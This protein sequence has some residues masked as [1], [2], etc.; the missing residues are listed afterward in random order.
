MKYAKLYTNYCITFL[1]ADDIINAVDVAA[2]RTG[3]AFSNQIKNNSSP[4]YAIDGNKTTCMETENMKETIW[5]LDLG[6]VNVI[7]GVTITPG[8][9]IKLQ[10]NQSINEF[11]S[12]H[13]Q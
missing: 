6:E 5:T 9:W 7:T 10:L 4:D 2:G 13:S 1:T 11:F 3:D 8:Q 12:T